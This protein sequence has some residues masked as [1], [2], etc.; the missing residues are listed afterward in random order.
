MRVAPLDLWAKLAKR[1]T[2]IG[3]QGIVR[4]AMAGL[5]RRGWDALALAAGLPLA[6][7]LGGTPRPIRA[8]NSCG[9]GLMA[10]RSGRRRSRE[11]ARGRLSRRQAAA[12]LSD[13]R[14]RTSRRVRAVRKRVGDGVEIMVDY[15]QALGVAEAL[16]ARPRARRRGRVLDR[17]ADP[18]RRLCRRAQARARARDADADRREF[19]ASRTRWQR[20]SRPAPA[21]T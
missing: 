21:T 14:S 10:P 2:L 13:A 9:L 1:F 3:V 5:R 16:R 20:R 11:A 6:R 8:Y 7:L 18:P 19:L 12:G 4:M 15:N 17:G